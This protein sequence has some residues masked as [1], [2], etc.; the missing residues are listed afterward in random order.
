[1]MPRVMLRCVYVAMKIVTLMRQMI[2]ARQFARD[3]Y[4][5]TGGSD[6][7]SAQS[8]EQHGIIGLWLQFGRVQRRLA[9]ASGI[10]S[11]RSCWS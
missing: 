1:M 4:I 10:A 5:S 3:R 8:I 9:L 6:T 2:S 7:V 11:R